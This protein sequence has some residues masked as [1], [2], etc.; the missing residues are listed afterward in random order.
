M[1][2]YPTDISL[3]VGSEDRRQ[4]RRLALA[5]TAQVFR[6]NGRMLPA[7]TENM[8]NCG[9]YCRVA[10][11]MMPGEEFNCFIRLPSAQSSALGGTLVLA[12][13]C[14]VARVESFSP[15]CYGIGCR[16]ED[17]LITPE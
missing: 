10:E 12:C 14:R 16:I 2:A 9:F 17:F 13:R 4:G 6:K 15:D 7:V 8:S 3:H 11:R 5:C 1:A